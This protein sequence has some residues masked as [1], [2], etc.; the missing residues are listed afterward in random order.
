MKTAR[1]EKIAEEIR[2]EVSTILLFELQDPRVSGVTVT[3]VKMTPDLQLARVYFT[4]PGEPQ[5]K[6]E[7]LKGL[8][9]CSGLIRKLVSQRITLKFMPTFD[10]FYDESLELQ[11][12]IDTLFDEIEKKRE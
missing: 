3:G 1:Q 2:R 4:I 6:E 11:E 10:F 7:A 9:S 5:R 12:R 8:K